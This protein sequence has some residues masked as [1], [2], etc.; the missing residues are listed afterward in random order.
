[1]NLYFISGLGADDRAFDQLVF[2][3]SWRI[4]HLEWIPVQKNE[5]LQSYARKFALRIDTNEPFTLIGLSFGG[6]MAIEINQIIKAQNLILI[7][8]IVTKNEL[9]PF[10]KFVKFTRIN[11]IIPASWFNMVFPF[12][13]WYFGVKKEEDKKLLDQF[14]RNSPASFIKWA[15]HQIIHWKNH[16]RPKNLYHIHGIND[17]VFPCQYVQA[18]CLV[19]RG[20]HLMIRDDATSINKAIMN[21]L[22]QINKNQ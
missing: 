11:R 5:T 16:E 4:T 7:S 22:E 14:I 3:D 8:S 18:D 19:N 9:P 15:I 1:M 20:G 10:M 21:H 6:I 17:K 12:T 13:Y 2:P